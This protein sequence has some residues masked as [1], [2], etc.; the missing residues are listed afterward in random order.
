MNTHIEYRDYT[1]ILMKQQALS[2]GEYQKVYYSDGVRT[3]LKYINEGDDE[4]MPKI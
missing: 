3:K 4:D 1:E 2:L